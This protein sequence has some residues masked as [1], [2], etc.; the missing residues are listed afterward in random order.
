MA[1][2]MGYQNNDASPE[3]FADE[4]S[5][6]DGYFHHRSQH[7]HHPQRLASERESSGDSNQA[8]VET[9]QIS[10]VG[11]AGSVNHDGKGHEG[12]QRSL[13]EFRWHGETSRT[14]RPPSMG[15]FE[16]EHTD[17]DSEQAPLLSPA[18]PAYS[19]ATVNPFHLPGNNGAGGET[20]NVGGYGTTTTTGPS[21]RS[22]R[23]HE[24]Q[25]MSAPADHNTAQNT[26][27]RQ[28]VRRSPRGCSC[29]FLG[30]MLAALVVFVIGVVF[31]M[32]LIGG[33]HAKRVNT[34]H[35]QVIS[36]G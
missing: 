18:P 9:N 33:A 6:T 25:S 5:P 23:Y 13:D 11:G 1:R 32:Y 24:P 35:K 22:S 2:S 26:W 30:K 16:S 14:A 15:R 28:V 31:M 21:N 7:S 8:G 3:E 17:Q 10:R 4:L 27:R 36:F 34:P 19:A 12:S 20:M 29:T